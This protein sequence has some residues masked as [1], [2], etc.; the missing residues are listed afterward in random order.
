M[1]YHKVIDYLTDTFS[2]FPFLIQEVKKLDLFKD[3]GIKIADLTLGMRNITI[4]GS[5]KEIFGTY[6][7]D[8]EDGT[9]G[10]VGSFL[11]SD[12]TGDIRIVLWDDKVKYIRYNEFNVGRSLYIVNG[13]TKQGRNDLGI[14]IHVSTF[15]DISLFPE[16]IEFYKRNCSKSLAKYTDR[17]Q[18]TS[19]IETYTI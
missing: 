5:I 16:F 18:K 13:Y 6:K 12:S 9:K 14:E 11:L 3:K 2:G 15:G 17:G 7:F 10:K 19:K 4:T 1:N 8:K